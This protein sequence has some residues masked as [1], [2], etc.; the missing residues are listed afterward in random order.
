MTGL[1]VKKVRMRRGEIKLVHLWRNKSKN[2]E[3]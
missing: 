1:S 2:T 3:N